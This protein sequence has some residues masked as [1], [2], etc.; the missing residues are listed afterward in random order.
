MFG[1]VGEAIGFAIGYATLAG[2]GIDYALNGRETALLVLGTLAGVALWGASASASA[3][4]LVLDVAHV[5]R[6]A[7]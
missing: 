3:L 5:G 4:I 1:V 7:A 2:R 6:S